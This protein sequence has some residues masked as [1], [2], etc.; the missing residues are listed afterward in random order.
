MNHQELQ[1]LVSAFVDGETNIAETD[2]VQ[3]HL[4]G[5]LSCRHDVESVQKIRSDLRTQNIIELSSSFT[6]RVMHVV[7]ERERRI[8]EWL[9][10]EPLARNTFF[11]IAVS[12]LLVFLLTSFNHDSPP[13]IAEVLINGVGSDSTAATV[14]LQPGEITKNDVLNVVLTK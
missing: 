10:V 11:A 14:L 4:L 1:M 3:Q 2:V 6:A 5:C 9:G 7:E 12:V 8:K 13:G